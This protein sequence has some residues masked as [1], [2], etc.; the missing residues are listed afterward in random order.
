MHL[1]V[2]AV[3]IPALAATLRRS[4]ARPGPT[5]RACLQVTPPSLPYEAPAD[6]TR[7]PTAGVP[8]TSNIA[9]PGH[10]DKSEPRLV[11]LLGA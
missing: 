10:A 6:P 5:L 3:L 1:A 4:I 9:R 2:A 11:E 7:H 8:T